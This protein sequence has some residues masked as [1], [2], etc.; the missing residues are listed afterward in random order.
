MEPARGQFAASTT[1]AE[2]IAWLRSAAEPQQITYLYVNDAEGQLVG[3]VVPRD[4]L[5]AA[6]DAPLDA[7]MLCAP[8]RLA[9]CQLM[10]RCRHDRTGHRARPAKRFVKS[11]KGPQ[12]PLVNPEEI[13]NVIGWKAYGGRCRSELVY[14]GADLCCRSRR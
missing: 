12:E 13:P 2:A 6:L 11:R 5:L 9:R 3:L 8:F 10:L 14:R 7:I 1:V 4:L